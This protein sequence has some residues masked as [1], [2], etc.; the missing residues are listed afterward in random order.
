MSGMGSKPLI[1]NALAEF[2][3]SG[4]SIAIAARDRRLAPHGTRAWAAT[5]DD[6]RLH[7]TIF[8]ET[9]SAEPITR[10]LEAHPE[11]AVTFDRP[12]DNSAWQIKGAY[13]ASRRCRPAERAEIERQAGSFLGELEMMGVPRSL[14]ERWPRW[15]CVA[16][17]I[18]VSD[19]FQQTPGPGAGE[20]V[21]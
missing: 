8:L 20:P 5:V 14:T 3:R 17:R 13:R 7:V 16:V 21:R 12:I 2:L 15:P 10:N 6:D 1:S 19:I 11:V 4:V 9:K 18:L